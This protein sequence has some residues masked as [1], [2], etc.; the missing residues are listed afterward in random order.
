[1]EHP[2]SATEHTNALSAAKNGWSFL[3]RTNLTHGE[4]SNDDEWRGVRR[5]D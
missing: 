3:I 4:R 5:G 2:A 1:L